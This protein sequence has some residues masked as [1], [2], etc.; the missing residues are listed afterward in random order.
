V[1]AEFSSADEFAFYDFTCRG[2]DNQKRILFVSAEKMNFWALREN[3]KRG[4][5]RQ[6]V[7]PKSVLAQ[8]HKIC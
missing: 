3:T 7:K 5:M 8:T 1:S 2:L 6:N 4:V